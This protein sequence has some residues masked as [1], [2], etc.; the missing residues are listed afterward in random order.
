M[1]KRTASVALL[2]ALN[3]A[4]IVSAKHSFDVLKKEEIKVESI[5]EINDEIS[6]LQNEEQTK[7]IINEYKN[8]YNYNV[9]YPYEEGYIQENYLNILLSY[10]TDHVDFKEENTLSSEEIIDLIEENSKITQSGYTSAFVVDG[11]YLKDILKEII[12]E[13]IESKINDINEDLYLIKNLKIIYAPYEF[14]E[15]YQDQKTDGIYYDKVNNTII[16]HR[17]SMLE[18]NNDIQEALKI[19]IAHTINDIRQVDPINNRNFLNYSYDY[20]NMF[21][22]DAS[23]RYNKIGTKEKD[24]ITDEMALN[25]LGVFSNNTPDDLY[26]AL[27]D[28]NLSKVFKILNLKS[29]EDVY[30]FYKMLY[31][32]DAKVYN[33]D[34]FDY[35]SSVEHNSKTESLSSGIGYS[36]KVVLYNHYV[37]NLLEYL[38]TNDLSLLDNLTLYYLGL[39]VICYNLDLD[40]PN[41]NYL[42]SVDA[43]LF[44]HDNYIHFLEDYYNVSY[45]TICSCENSI[46]INLSTIS[47]GTSNLINKLPMLKIFTT[48]NI[49]VDSYKVLF[50]KD[51][52][53]VLK[54]A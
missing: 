48:V 16:I 15:Q 14:V 2:I 4:V 53:K 41:E 26:A 52:V 11:D 25:L 9:S 32:I 20:N 8:R 19:N 44:G 27:F 37:K 23:S 13:I 35:Y 24:Y 7:N 40:N 1:F 6:L 43:I 22:E 30:D 3:A 21:I 38:K 54:T 31:A 18:K 39:N 46:K 34:F 42:Y 50:N 47:N 5:E 51:I 36:H 28:E 33:N 29:K 49:D 12:D 10:Y 17:D 45:E